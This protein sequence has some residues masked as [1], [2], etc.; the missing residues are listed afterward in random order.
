MFL[1]EFYQN[2]ETNLLRRIVNWIVEI[3]VVIAIAW[4][5]VDSFGT[6]VEVSGH[7]M[8]PVLESEDV[9]LL[10]RFIYEFTKPDRFDVVAF[11]RGDS[12][13]NMKRIIGLPGETVQIK[14]G[15]VYIDDQPLE[16]E[17]GL[18]SVSLA[19][20]AE[21]PILLAEQE[22]FLLGDNRDSSEDSR[23]A[24]IG[25]VSIE[26]ILGKA[27]MRVFPLIEIDLIR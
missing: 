19:G 27:W 14:G 13:I 10:N 21:K 26:Q 16:A 9:V 5:T 11:Q 6:Q 24:N 4:F 15:I 23:F 18:E 3:I 1:L 22:Y 2:E 7:S 20:L 17:N 12:K 25:N 8:M